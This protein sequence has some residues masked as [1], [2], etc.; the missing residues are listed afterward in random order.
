VPQLRILGQ[1]PDEHDAI[2]VRHV[3]YSSSELVFDSA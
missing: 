2:D 3:F 1:V